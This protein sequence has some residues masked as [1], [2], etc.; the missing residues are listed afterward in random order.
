MTTRSG[1]KSSMRQ[2]QLRRAAEKIKVRSAII[3]NNEQIKSLRE[4]NVTLR[5]KM[6]QI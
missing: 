5:Y 4:R 6:K 3:R 1:N 2:A